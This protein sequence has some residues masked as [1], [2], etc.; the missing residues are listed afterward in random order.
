[1]KHLPL[2]DKIPNFSNLLEKLKKHFFTVPFLVIFN[3]LALLIL[4]GLSLY[5]KLNNQGDGVERLFSDP[6][7]FW[8][9]YEGL[10]TGISEVL[11]C[12]PVA[13]CAFT[14]GLLRQK[15][16]RSRSAIF[17]FFSALLLGVFFLDDR[18]R[19]TLIL[20]QLGI[21]KKLIYLCYG[22][23]VFLY[24]IKFWRYI[25]TTPYLPLI[26]AFLLFAISR[27]EDIIDTRSLG[28]HAM[29]EDGTKL[30][31]LLNLAMYFWHVCY[32]AIWRHLQQTEK[33]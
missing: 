20:S 10:F 14:F 21:S 33:P 28:A 1:M 24:G 9:P 25:K 31:A 5:A 30:L 27:F 16:P 12:I 2:F 4:G 3:T 8:F 15:D 11:W 19:M 6:F 18:F 13:I 17:F 23:G 29:L 7:N 32:Q 22:S 26:A